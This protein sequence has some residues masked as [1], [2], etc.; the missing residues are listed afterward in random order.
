VVPTALCPAQYTLRFLENQQMQHGQLAYRMGEALDH[1]LKIICYK[2]FAPSETES[3]NVNS[4]HLSSKTLGQAAQIA[5]QIEWLEKQLDDLL[6]G[7]RQKV[8]G[9]AIRVVWRDG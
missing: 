5:E 8:G 6:Q 7:E 4:M 3:T 2:C 9:R 1:T